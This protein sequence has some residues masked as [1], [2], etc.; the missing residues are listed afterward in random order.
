MF[1]SIFFIVSG[2]KKADTPKPAE[3]PAAVPTEPA[4]APGEE[5]AK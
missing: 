4:P 3:Q 1:I 5:G 2:C